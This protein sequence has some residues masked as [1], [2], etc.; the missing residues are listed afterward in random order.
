[1]AAF[2]YGSGNDGQIW[3]SKDYLIGTAYGG[4]SE[5]MALYHVSADSNFTDAQ[6]KAYLPTI[7]WWV[8]IRKV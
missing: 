8:E 2:N 6:A 3:P 1:M 4:I 7:E 5:K